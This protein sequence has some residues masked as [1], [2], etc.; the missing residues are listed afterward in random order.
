MASTG[1]GLRSN[2]DYRLYLK[3]LQTAWESNNQIDR[4]E[5][6][7]FSTLREELGI[8]LLFPVDKMFKKI[9]MQGETYSFAI[10]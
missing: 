1:E 6:I 9:L 10:H 4:S 7:L 5:A 2:K 3:M 8:W